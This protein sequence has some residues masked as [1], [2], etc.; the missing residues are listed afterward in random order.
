M[1]SGLF[2]IFV[3][4]L[5]PV[6][7]LPGQSP[8]VPSPFRD[9]SVLHAISSAVN[10]SYDEHAPRLST[11]GRTL[12]FS[13]NDHP[14]NFGQANAAD[15]WV[16]YYRPAERLWSQ[17]INLGRPLNDERND[18]VAGI[19]MSDTRIYLIKE[20]PAGQSPIFVTERSGRSWSLPR[21]LRIDS[22]RSG[23][24]HIDAFVN[25]EEEVLLVSMDTDGGS[26][27]RDLYVSLRRPDGAW[28]PLRHL[29]DGLNTPGDE[30]SMQLAPDGRT[31]YFASNGLP[32]IGGADLFMS[33][34]LDDSWTKWT[35]PLHLGDT[36]NTPA[37]E[38]DFTL[39][40]DGSRLLLTRRAR[41][42]APS[43]L[44]SVRLP[45]E[46]RPVPTVLVRGRLS[47]PSRHTRLFWAP[48]ADRA[49][50]PQEVTLRSDGRF[51]LVLPAD[52]P[53]VALYA[54]DID[55]YGLTSCIALAG[56][57]PER[58]DQESPALATIHNKYPAY[59]QREEQI[60]KLRSQLE[61]AQAQHR[62]LQ[63]NLMDY[64]R[65]GLP[66]LELR[67]QYLTDPVY[68]PFEAQYRQLIGEASPDSDNAYPPFCYSVWRQLAEGLLPQ[69]KWQLDSTLVTEDLLAQKQVR[70]PDA[71][72]VYFLE[73]R[74]VALAQSE[75][76]TSMK[77]ITDRIALSA[78]GA[79]Q[80][81]QALCA[82][83]EPQLWQDLTTALEPYARRALTD[84]QRY[85]Q[86]IR[87]I[88]NLERELSAQIEEQIALESENS[89]LARRNVTTQPR[90]PAGMRA[91]FREIAVN[92]MLIPLEP[93]RRFPL[94]AVFFEA[95]RA[96]LLPASNLELQRLALAL[97]QNEQLAV[98]IN[99]HTHTGLSHHHAEELTQ[100]R[101]DA[102]ANRL[103]MFGIDPERII[104]LGR[105]KVFTLRDDSGQEARLENQRVEVRLLPRE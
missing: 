70:R 71:T 92:T 23:T 54:T 76:N 96:V 31:L 56:A 37:D 18:R 50:S 43:D 45:A 42:G 29:G 105:G 69:I 34:R 78:P 39:T 86:K 68:E 12:Y 47:D 49:A 97:L 52:L 9:S 20:A 59:Q 103:I 51:R 13:R 10:S 79:A 19:N 3:F 16:S 53:A 66:R 33:R 99:V 27:G 85:E 77:T 57:L 101:A 17:A 15:I 41:E 44:Y 95:D 72:T 90:M 30:G 63:S 55:G 40:P 48:I 91:D 73:Q 21:A 98:E 28:S 88:N 35:A 83:L 26:R 25:G 75:P 58:P 61:D 82:Q 87:Q 38:S 7:T 102:I 100:A 46:A 32:G 80:V 62:G 94:N 14:L 22:L 74:L 4:W 11:D 60:A 84:A 8:G 67:P 1:K 36:I 5:L 81:T 24:P 65:I 64:D 89:L 6:A 93:Y 2:S 104:A